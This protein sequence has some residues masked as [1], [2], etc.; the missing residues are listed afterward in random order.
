[1]PAQGSVKSKT[2]LCLAEMCLKFG[3]RIKEVWSIDRTYLHRSRE[4]MMEAAAK[5]DATH[6]MF[7]DS[8]VIFEPD[9]MEKLLR[10]GL[11]V[12]GATYRMRDQLRRVAAHKPLD[13]EYGAAREIRLADKQNKTHEVRAVP[14]G[15]ML[16]DLDVVRA[17]PQPWFDFGRNNPDEW[18]GEDVFF[19]EK[20]REHGHQIWMD[21]TIPVGHIGDWVY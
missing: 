16:V 10:Q 18:M 15:F 11:G 19:C 6:L 1:M 4:S 12:V 2:S 20:L 8:D 14:T 17:I 7:I 13:A 9:A 5:T 3:H 21:P